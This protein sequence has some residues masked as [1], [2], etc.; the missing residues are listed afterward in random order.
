MYTVI[1]A[2]KEQANQIL[3]KHLKNK[4]RTLTVFERLRGV[5]KDIIAITKS[6]YV[7][8]NEDD[9]GIVMLSLSSG[10]TCTYQL[11]NQTTPCYIEFTGFPNRS[12]R[13]DIDYPEGE[14]LDILKAEGIKAKENF[15]KGGEI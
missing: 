11:R 9:M 12:I 10:V 13:Y 7:Y 3:E 1:H 5:E 15:W 14:M 4:E 2:S 8:D 6:S